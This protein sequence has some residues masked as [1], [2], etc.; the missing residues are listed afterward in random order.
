VKNGEPILAVGVG[1]FF[2][3]LQT[4]GAVLLFLSMGQLDDFLTRANVDAANVMGES[5]A[6]G[7]QTVLAVFDE[8]RQEWGMS[9]YV[10]HTRPT[11][12]V[13]IPTAFLSVIPSKKDK[14]TRSSTG[15]RF[16]ITEVNISTGN[17]TLTATNE[18]A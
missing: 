7:G 9:E 4:G 13:V 10:E 17:V 11:V 5:I 6:I 1:S 2:C 15:D 12:S 8:Q 18:T 16:L 14:F 3:A